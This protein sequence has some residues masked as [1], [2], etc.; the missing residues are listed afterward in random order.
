MGTDPTV[1]FY[2]EGKSV[3]EKR[4]IYGIDSLSS[5][6]YGID[7]SR[8]IHSKSVFSVTNL[9]DAIV[10][11]RQYGYKEDGIWQ[12]AFAGNNANIRLQFQGYRRRLE[13]AVIIS[14]DPNKSGAKIPYSFLV[15][16]DTEELTPIELDN[17]SLGEDT[18]SIDRISRINGK[19]NFSAESDD[20]L[21]LLRMARKIG[22]SPRMILQN[23]R[24]DEDHSK[25]NINLQND[26][27]YGCGRI[28]CHELD[29]SLIYRLNW[30]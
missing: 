30:H 25:G 26:S 1:I 4:P 7:N 22:Y 28:T 19:S 3:L 12:T 17:E 2:D 29:S 16:E 15:P 27:G 9:E 6:L 5:F 23:D 8:V 14:I 18:N 24:G 21:K 13:S 10:R 20:L 11:A